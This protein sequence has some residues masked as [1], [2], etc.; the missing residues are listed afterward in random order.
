MVRACAVPKTRET[1]RIAHQ[2]LRRQASKTGTQLQ[3]QMLESAR[4][5]SCSRPSRRP[6]SEPRRCS[7]DPARGV[8]FK[9]SKS[10]A[11][12]GHLPNHDEQSAK[13][14]PYGKLFVALLVE[15]LIGHARALSFWGYELEPAQARER[16]A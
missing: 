10:L 3:P 11:E 13:A 15:E 1:I 5:G 6:R 16:P 14:W 4:F 12:L 2:S 7:R 9:R 8:M